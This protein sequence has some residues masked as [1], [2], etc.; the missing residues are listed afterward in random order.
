[1]IF[2]LPINK[3][4]RGY[5]VGRIWPEHRKKKLYEFYAGMAVEE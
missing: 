2:G 1:M 5:I 4:G 3:E